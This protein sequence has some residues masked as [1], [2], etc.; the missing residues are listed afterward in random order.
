MLALNANRQKD[1]RVPRGYRTSGVAGGVD[2]VIDRVGGDRS[3]GMGSDI[4]SWCSV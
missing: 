4:G 3:G 1:V 2:V